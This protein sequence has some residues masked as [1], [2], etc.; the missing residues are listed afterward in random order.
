MTTH[1]DVAGV[2]PTERPPLVLI[3][4]VHEE[5]EIFFELL[6]KAPRGAQVIQL[7]DLPFYPHLER[8]HPWRRPPRP[9][10][11]IDGNHH[12]YDLTRGLTVPT[13]I[14]PGVTFLP[15]GTV[16]NLEGR[17]VGIL[18]GADSVIDV[19]FRVRGVD[20]WP[21]EERVS[22]ADVARLLANA[23]QVGGLDLLLTHTPP[24]SITTAMMRDGRPPHNSAVAV[25]VAWEALGRPE[26]ISGHMHEEAHGPS[27]EVVPF[28][29]VAVRP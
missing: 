15:R 6:E 24:A 18:G 28:L 12:S 29:G 23:E 7:G 19:P 5:R 13:E 3:G 21:D 2:I 17:R 8:R 10:S 22:D 25:E 14:R 26:I 27:F 9:F 11:M 16:L 20:W 4:D 1:P